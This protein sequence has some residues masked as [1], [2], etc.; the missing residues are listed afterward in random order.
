LQ[1]GLPEN[2]IDRAI[3]PQQRGVSKDIRSEAL[4]GYHAVVVGRRGTNRDRSSFIG[5]VANDLANTLLH[6]PLGIVSGPG[7]T[8]KIM[9]CVD[10]SKASMRALDVMG[11]VCNKVLFMAQEKTVWIV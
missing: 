1:E 6:H 10:R 4:R 8:G 3:E 11:K 7:D 5:G 9:L 2:G